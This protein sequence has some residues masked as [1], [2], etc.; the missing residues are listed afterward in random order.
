MTAYVKLELTEVDS[1][2]RNTNN[3]KSYI[4]AEVNEENKVVNMKSLLSILTLDLS[5]EIR[6]RIDSED[7]RELDAFEE[8]IKRYG[9]RVDENY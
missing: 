7:K 9:G 1:F 5:K 3:I 6:V 4:Y 2:C 8:I